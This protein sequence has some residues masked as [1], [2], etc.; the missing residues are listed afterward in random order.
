MFDLAQGRVRR[1]RARSA[2][3]AAT[4]RDP[5]QA[6]SA[7]VLKNDG[8]EAW[9]LGDGVLGLTF[10]T[11]ANSI[12]PDVIQMINDA[13]E[14]GRD[15]TSARWSSPTRASTSASA[16]TC[17]S[18]SW[19]RARSSGTR[20]ATMVKGY[21]DATPAHEVRDRAG[22]RR[23][24]R[25]DARRRP[26]AV[27]RRAA[28][29]QAAA[30]TYAGLVEVGVGL[31]PGGGGTMNM[32][33]RALEGVPEGAQRRHVRARHAGVQ[34][35]RAGAGRDQRRRGEGARLLPATATACRST[36]RA[37]SPTPRRGPS[38]SPRAGYHPPPPRALRASRRERHRHAHDDGRH[39]RRRRARE[40]ARRE[41][42]H[43]ARRRSSAAASAA[44]R[45]RS[46]R[47]RCSSSSARP[48]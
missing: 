1:A 17:S 45:A 47:T 43:E 2:R 15:A 14:Q 36:A 5:A 22:R 30:E 8:A 6:A 24:V 26:R 21:Q 3:I 13:V 16:P 32:L 46:P 31:I 44:R 40:R 7:P 33:W 39:A 29:V 18:S 34:E 27:L 25:D 20:S 4:L 10:K 9:D 12:D 48:S 19:R 41:D 28:T 11:K 23:A 37:S 42:R 38:A 35:H